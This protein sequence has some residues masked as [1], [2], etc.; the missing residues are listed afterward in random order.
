MRLLVLLLLA[1]LFTVFLIGAGLV[2]ATVAR[3]LAKGANSDRQQG[4]TQPPSAAA[5]GTAQVG[6][7]DGDIGNPASH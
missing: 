7:V 3:R 1:V 5:P 6:T 4:Q 2:V